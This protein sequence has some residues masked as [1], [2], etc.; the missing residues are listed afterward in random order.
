M[1]NCVREIQ[2]QYKNTSSVKQP[3]VTMPDDVA[4]FF[5]Q[6]LPSN[7]K[8][9]FI[10]LYLDG[11]KT[12]LGYNVVSTGT[13]TASLVHPREVFQ[14]AIHIG[15]VSLVVAHNHPSGNCVPSSADHA[16]TQKLKE[17][18]ELLGITLLD[19]IIISDSNHYSFMENFKL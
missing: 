2:I 17:V 15:A 4:E 18:G 14:P 13:A 5:R 9:S 16:V 6:V 10:A 12:P 8:E 11:S 7:S 19:H 3:A 1:E